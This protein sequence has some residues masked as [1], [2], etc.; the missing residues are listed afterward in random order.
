MAF[1]TVNPL[2]GDNNATKAQ[3]AAGT[4]Q[5]AH[6]SRA[7]WGSMDR[8]ARVSSEAAAGGDTAFVHTGIYNCPGT[9]E[10][11]E[12]SLYCE[13]SGSAGLPIVFKAVGTPELRTTVAESGVATATTANSL[14]DTTKSWSTGQFGSGADY[15]IKITACPD[16]PAA[17]GQIRDIDNNTSTPTTLV[18]TTGWAVQP[19]GA[20]I[21]YE[22]RANGP[23]VGGYTNR[24]YIQ[25]TV[26][27]IRTS[28]WFIDGNYCVNKGD[29][30][31]VVLYNCNNWLIEGF[32]I[33]Q[34]QRMYNDNVN[35]LRVEGADSCTVQ[36]CWLDGARHQSPT[37]HNGAAIMTYSATN[38][39][40]QNL[41]LT[42]SGCGISLKG[43]SAGPGT[44][45]SN[46]IRWNIIRQNRV[47]IRV[48]FSTGVAGLTNIYGNVIYDNT[49]APSGS[50]IELGSDA[51]NLRIYNNTIYGIQGNGMWYA[52]SASRTNVEWY[53]NLYANCTTA[54]NLGD[55]TSVGTDALDYDH[56]FIG[57]G[58]RFGAFNGSNHATR[59]NFSAA[60]S[61]EANG[62]DGDPLFVNAGAGNFRLGLTSPARSSGVGG[63]AVGA[64]PT[65]TEIIGP[66]LVPVTR[67]A[68][69]NGLGSSGAFV[70][71]LLH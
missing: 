62:G 34:I 47:G 63:A 69:L 31:Q 37:S 42:G 57:S 58:V 70:S 3:V 45:H 12:P 71:N 33:N 4:H 30:G 53:N 22:I 14:S 16:V 46:T 32:D 67:N 49:D 27:N 9:G 13:N 24:H 11:L 44:Q 21:Q 2:I 25:W 17:V 28:K 19:T 52:S 41:E 35:C 5:W 38:C 18:L 40:F 65:G 48:D 51:R 56:V 39:I 15:S 26:D 61:R 68:S 66:M 29:T 1:L 7:T 55:V 64:Y 54:V 60:T 43:E 20:G 6:V 8:N 36:N 50:G 59:A 23:V 10:R